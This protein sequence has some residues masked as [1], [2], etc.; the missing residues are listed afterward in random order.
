MIWLLSMMIVAAILG[1]FARWGI[2]QNLWG[3]LAVNVSGSL[4]AGWVAGSTKPDGWWST[5]ILVGLCGSLT[6]FSGFSVFMI[7]L[8][9]QGEIFKFAIHFFLNNALC[10]S[11]CYVGYLLASKS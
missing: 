1:T 9:Q 2:A 11:L 5:V 8:L 10:L 3:L 4:L 7:R 6:T